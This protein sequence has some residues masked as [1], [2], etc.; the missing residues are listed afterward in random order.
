MNREDEK[1][2]SRNVPQ[3]RESKSSLNRYYFWLK[4][5]RQPIDDSELLF[6]YVTSGGASDY[7]KRNA[8]AKIQEPTERAD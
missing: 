7:A 6:F 1:T 8:K 3:I 2:L 5:K 4:Y